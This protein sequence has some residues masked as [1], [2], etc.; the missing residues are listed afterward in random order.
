[1][2][3]FRVLYNSHMSLCVTFGSE[4]LEPMFRDIQCVLGVNLF[5]EKVNTFKR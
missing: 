5:N 1:M 2:R 3:I 4:E